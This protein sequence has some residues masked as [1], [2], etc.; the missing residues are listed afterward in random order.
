M[1]FKYVCDICGA[2]TLVEEGLV[3]PAGYMTPGETPQGWALLMVRPPQPQASPVQPYRPGPVGGQFV[4]AA[5]AYAPPMTSMVCCARCALEAL[6]RAGQF[7]QDCFA[8]T[9]G[10]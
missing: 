10:Q 8:Q 5:P 7:L 3:T 4:P 2:E 6:G 1:A 9:G